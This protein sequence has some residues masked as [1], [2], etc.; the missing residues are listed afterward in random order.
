MFLDSCRLS[1]SFKDFTRSI[2]LQQLW[3]DGKRDVCIDQIQLEKVESDGE[4]EERMK[5]TRGKHCAKESAGSTVEL[6]II[7]S[8][9]T[10][11]CGPSCNRIKR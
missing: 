3:Q 7:L 1:S 6:F 5:G 10:A 2:L 8:L 4:A 9:V 11:T